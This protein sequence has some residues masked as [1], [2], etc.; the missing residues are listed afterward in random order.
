MQ[1]LDSE[2]ARTFSTL[3]ARDMSAIGAVQFCQAAGKLPARQEVAQAVQLRAGPSP[4][5]RSLDSKRTCDCITGDIKGCERC[6]ACETSW[7]C[8]LQPDPMLS[9]RGWQVYGG[10]CMQRCLCRVSIR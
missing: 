9:D 5:S 7:Q 4:L 2:S 8:A 1:Q 3:L 10:K 6:K